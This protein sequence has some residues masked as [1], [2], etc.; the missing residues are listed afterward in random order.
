M[1]PVVTSWLRSRE[2]RQER[3]RE[4]QRELRQMIERRL[5]DCGGARVAAFHMMVDMLSGISPPE[6]YHR[7]VVEQQARTAD[8]AQH[9][10]E[11]YR[12]RDERLRSLVE[13]LHDS[14][15][16]FETHHLTVA[17]MSPDDWRAAITEKE[18]S[19]R[20]IERQVRLRLDE[21]RW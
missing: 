9:K 8:H 10:W 15:L 7:A 3:E 5:D 14:L 20:E 16:H 4:I 17:T 6:A 18:R 11:P 21:L 2:H 12:I 1:G 13:Q 19:L